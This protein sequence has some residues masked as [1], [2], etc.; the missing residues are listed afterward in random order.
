MSYFSI[1][2]ITFIL[3][4]VSMS[5][6]TTIA[7]QDV[8]VLQ[9]DGTIISA[10]GVVDIRNAIRKFYATYPNKDVYDFLSFFMTA[11]DPVQP[12]YHFPVKNDISGIGQSIFDS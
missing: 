7:S 1:C 4:F 2:F 6:N 9:D 8:Y 10:E 3:V 12:H 11:N 5:T